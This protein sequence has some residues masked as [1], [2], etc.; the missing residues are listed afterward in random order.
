M[1]Q[2]DPSFVLELEL[3]LSLRKKNVHR[4]HVFLSLDGFMFLAQHPP[5][6]GSICRPRCLVCLLLWPAHSLLK[7]GDLAPLDKDFRTQRREVTCLKPPSLW[8][9]EPG[10]EPR[11]TRLSLVQWFSAAAASRPIRS[12]L[13]GVAPRHLDLLRLFRWSQDVARLVTTTVAFAQVP[14]S[15]PCWVPSWVLQTCQ[16]KA[17]GSS[18]DHKSPFSCLTF[19]LHPQPLL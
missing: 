16:I 15:P 9:A 12:E 6:R 4:P 2:G 11:C 7:T 10:L 18:L 5:A 13:W 1:G 19:L 8:V 14:I 3:K 17:W